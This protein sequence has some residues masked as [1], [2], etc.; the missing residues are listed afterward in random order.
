[1]Q[2]VAEADF[3]PVGIYRNVI[4]L[5]CLRCRT[6]RLDAWNQIGRLGQRRYI[7]EDGY[8]EFGDQLKEGGKPDDNRWTTA[9]RRYLDMRRS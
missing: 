8:R 5:R 3:H 7:Y 9:K 1:M 2:E 6:L 4:S